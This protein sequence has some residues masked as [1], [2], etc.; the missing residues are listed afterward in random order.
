MPS[1]MELP[2]YSV[3]SSPSMSLADFDYDSDL[4]V[5]QMR[6]RESRPM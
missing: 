4:P 5:D 3:P 6:T 1:E 2:N